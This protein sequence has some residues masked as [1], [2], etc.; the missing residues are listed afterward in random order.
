MKTTRKRTRRIVATLAL[1][2]SALF[3]VVAAPASANTVSG[4]TCNGV[5]SIYRWATNYQ[6][7]SGLSYSPTCLTDPAGVRMVWQA[8]GNLV[9]YDGQ[10]SGGIALWASN[11]TGQNAYFDLQTDGNMVIR[12]G[13]DGAAI[14]NF[15]TGGHGGH[16]F[17]FQFDIHT[18]FTMT[19]LYGFPATNQWYQSKQYRYHS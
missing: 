8:D 15:G 13:S 9:I 17:T 14:W 1:A 6:W 4:T 10:H 2:S 7:K 19:E 12:R 5:N 18:L 11:T 16:G 3:G